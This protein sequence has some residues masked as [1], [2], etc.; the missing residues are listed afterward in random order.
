M[1]KVI[2]GGAISLDHYIARKDGAVDWLQW[3]D[4]VQKIMAEM[5]PRFDVM[6]MGRKTWQH[7]QEQFSEEDLEKARSLHSG[8]KEY[9]FSRTLPAGEAKGGYEIVNSDP[10]EFVRELKKQPGKD[11]MVMGGGDLAKTL[12]EAGVIDEIGFNIQPVLLGSGIPLYH[13]M[14]RQID[15]ELIECRALKK[16]CVY[17]TYKVRNEK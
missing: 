7:A 3:S 1:R 4:D 5:W 16:G 17:I 13:E 14:S 15:L 10:G 11:I 12:F 6:V 9:V 2:F 8:M